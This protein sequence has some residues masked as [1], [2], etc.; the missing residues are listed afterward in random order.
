MQ[1]WSVQGIQILCPMI[2]PNTRFAHHAYKVQDIADPANNRQEA[3]RQLDGDQSL[4][5]GRRHTDR[6]CYWK[7]VPVEWI[8]LAMISWIWTLVDDQFAH[9]GFV[10]SEC[11]LTHSCLSNRHHSD[12][13][14]FVIIGSQSGERETQIAWIRCMW[15][16]R[17]VIQFDSV[18]HIRYSV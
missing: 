5:Q 11:R 14:F 8:E 10:F 3:K 13:F 6:D 9:S 17:F 2:E 18:A 4:W 7:Q 15:P 16:L 1:C 12:G